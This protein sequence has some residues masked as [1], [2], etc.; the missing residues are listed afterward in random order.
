M[1][2]DDD[3]IDLPAGDAEPGWRR[4]ARTNRPRADLAEDLAF[5][6][7]HGGYRHAPI[8][9]AAMRL[10]VTPEALEQAQ[11]RTARADREAEAG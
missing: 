10:G 11:C 9:V 6:R 1:A 3:L 2:Y 4:S 8:A 7:E 5:V